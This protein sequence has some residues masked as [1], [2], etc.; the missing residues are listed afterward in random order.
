MDRE[1]KTA[2]REAKTTNRDT[3]LE[4]EKS[5]RAT[6]KTEARRDP[7]RKKYFATFPYPYM[8][9]TLHLGHSLTASRAVFLAEFYRLNG[10]NVLF[11]FAFHGTGMPIVACAAKLRDELDKYAE[12]DYDM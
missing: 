8:N 9:G 10:H 11:P 7:E 6:W 1:T 2:D 5:V 12:A 4:I 3:I